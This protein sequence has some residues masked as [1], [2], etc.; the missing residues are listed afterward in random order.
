MAGP[1]R[2]KKL[3]KVKTKPLRKG[4]QGPN[5]GPLRLSPKAKRAQLAQKTAK[6]PGK[7]GKTVSAMEERRRRMKKAL[8]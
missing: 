7:L 1:T 5:E 8:D 3:I 4:K 2:K 6:T